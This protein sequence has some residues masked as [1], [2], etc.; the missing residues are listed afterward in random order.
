[1]TARS[2]LPCL[3]LA[4][5]LGPFGASAAAADA[6]PFTIVAPAEVV[7]GQAFLV[8]L[9][10][11]QT[12]PGCEVNFLGRTYHTWAEAGEVR[13][14]VAVAAEDPGGA[15]L[16]IFGWQ[17]GA[18]GRCAIGLR[19]DVRP[20][21]FGEQRLSLPHNMVSPDA[22]TMERIGAEK[23]RL[24]ACL[25]TACPDH[26][27]GSGFCRPVAGAI[28]SPFGLR[29][30]LNGEPKSPHA[31]VDFKAAMGEPVH[32]AAAGRVALVA[33]FY[34]EGNLVVIDHGLGLSTFY[35]HLSEARVK[36][37]DVVEKGQVIGLAGASGRATGPHLHFGARVGEVR[38]DPL[39]LL[40]LVGGTF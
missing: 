37:G 12:P 1:M 34:L 5:C 7:Q 40:K 16:L 3:V 29:R 11:P 22:L 20:A 27:W 36:E 30:V 28:I 13:A 2:S 10:G 19:V 15:C 23:E 4:L 32:A 21:A 26:L 8:A 9:K 24:A 18:G 35:C 6:N 38:I 17:D 14:L 33:P 25:A 31:G 39:S